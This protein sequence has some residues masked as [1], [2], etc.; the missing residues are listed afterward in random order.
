MS[1]NRYAAKRD[2]SEPGIV[3]YLRIR[4]AL[5]ER[6]SGFRTPD[7]LVGWCGR[8][9]LMECKTEKA[10]LNEGQAEFFSEAQRKGLPCYLVRSVE[11]V[12]KI[13]NRH[14]RVSGL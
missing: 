9:L 14:L 2:S 3:E 7:L 8:W 11:D 13:L 10:K 6:V 5:V 12:E 4:G 1:L